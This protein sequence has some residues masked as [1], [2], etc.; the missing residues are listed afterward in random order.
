MTQHEYE[1]SYDAFVGSMHKLTMGQLA[2]RLK[3]LPE[4]P[5]AIK[6]ALDKCVTARNVLAHHYFWERAGHFAISDGQRQM[7]YECDTYKAQFEVATEQIDRFLEPYRV[8]IGL[9]PSVQLYNM[10]R[11]IDAARSSLVQSHSEKIA[12]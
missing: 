4:V 3:N 2:T 5:D 6:D 8:Q 1:E 10:D 11:L 12:D 7:L 9:S